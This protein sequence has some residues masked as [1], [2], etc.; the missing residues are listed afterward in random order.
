MAA[1]APKTV[2]KA[3]DSTS[4]DWGAAGRKDTYE[5]YF[6]NP[7][8]LQE[9]GKVDV[10]ASQSS[11]TWGY[12]T[13]NK[14]TGSF[15][16]LNNIGRN[17]LIRVK[18]TIEI[19]NQPIYSRTLGTLF[20]ENSGESAKYK[21][22]QT[23]LSCYSTLWR[24]T[25]DILSQD[26]YRPTGYNIIQEMRE[27]VE[28]DGGKFQVMPSVDTTQTH[29]RDILFEMGTNRATVLN[30]IAGWIGCQIYPDEDGY[31]TLD[32]YVAPQDRQVSYTFESGENCIYLSGADTEENSSSINRVICFYQAQGTENGQSVVHSDVVTLDLDAG[33]P[34]SYQ[35]IGRRV[36]YKLQYPD[37]RYNEN[38]PSRQQLTDYGNA[39]L[40]NHSSV[41]TRYL[42]IEA[43]NVP[44]LKTGDV[45]RYMNDIDFET[46][47]NVKAEV[48]EMDM[49]LNLGGMTK[50]RLK[51]IG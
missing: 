51:V 46:P 9:E 31:I 35:N 12:Y 2:A 29:T 28:A 47:I 36:S 19:P 17:K 32:R 3:P 13:D 1:K 34:F 25:Q 42:E 16:A 50:Y 37:V 40:R 48:T 8:T 43:A 39:Y 18:Q 44:T 7:F 4:I 27:L 41:G 33:N 38:E 22:T 10:D 5:F 23:S 15:K 21:L 30:T 24:F 11:L 45:V 20:V 26:F 14:L 49:K 6:V